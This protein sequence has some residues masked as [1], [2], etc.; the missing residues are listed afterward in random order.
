MCPGK[1]E[2]LTLC[3]AHHGKGPELNFFLALAALAKAETTT[4]PTIPP[5]NSQQGPGTGLLTLL[6]DLLPSWVPSPDPNLIHSSLGL[7]WP[8]C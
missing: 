7:L 1:Q 5:P 4:L 3:Q 6:K 2:A 8:L